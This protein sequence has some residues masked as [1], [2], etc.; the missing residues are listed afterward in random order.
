[1]TD[2]FHCHRQWRISLYYRAARSG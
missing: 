1:M 2:I